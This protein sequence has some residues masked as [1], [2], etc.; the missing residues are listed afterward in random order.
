MILCDNPGF[1]DTRGSEYEICTSLSIDRAMKA[2]EKIRAVVLVI[3]YDCFTTE[4]ANPLVKTLILMQDRFPQILDE[5]A[6][7]MYILITKC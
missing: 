7:S 6:Q 3:S 2:A 4:R 5:H 1:N